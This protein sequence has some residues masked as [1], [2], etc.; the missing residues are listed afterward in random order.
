[1]I[2]SAI[3]PSKQRRRDRCLRNL[4]ILELDG[5]GEFTTCVM[6]RGYWLE[7]GV[8]GADVRAD[9]EAQELEED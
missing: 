6:L 7:D 2:V 1:M 5:D 3:T 8:I 4:A 9:E